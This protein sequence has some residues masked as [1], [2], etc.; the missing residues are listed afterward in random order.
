MAARLY[1][2]PMLP[3][4][5]AHRAMALFTRVDENVLVGVAPVAFSVAP[6]RLR[7]M[8]VTGVVN[9][10]DEYSGP[11]QTYEALGIEQLYL[12]TVDHT[13]VSSSLSPPLPPPSAPPSPLP[14]RAWLI[15]RSLSI[16]Y[17]ES[18]RRAGRCTFTA[19]QATGGLLL[20]AFATWSRSTPTLPPWKFRQCYP[21]SAGYAK[22]CTFSA[23]STRSVTDF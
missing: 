17:T 8:G 15:C 19:R 3:I 21:R 22:S 10:C 9:L 11:V 5:L 2:W 20:F 13:E 1:F 12:P 6:G 18:P 14:S 7:D 23:T 4:T 16:S